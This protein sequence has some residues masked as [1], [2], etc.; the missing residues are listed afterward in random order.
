MTYDAVHDRRLLTGPLDNDPEVHQRVARLRMLG[1]GVR[2]E[3]EFDEFASK[4]AQSAATLIGSPA[5][6]YAMVNF[7][8]DKR[9]YFA[10]LHTPA[11]SRAGAALDA[12][13][14]AVEEPTREMTRDRGWCPE[15]VSR[16][17]PLVLNDVCANPRF[18]ANRVVDELNI[19]SYMGAPLIDR[20]GTVLG[21]VCVVDT[22]ERQWGRAGWDMIEAKAGELMELLH[23]R[24]MNR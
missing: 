20:T 10:G 21:T 14:A 16:R 22:E 5:T 1:L 9:Q 8:D 7:I 17:R 18:G 13:K 3:P 19:R 6:P 2:P 11:T 4:L 12:A 15:V 24:E 23:R